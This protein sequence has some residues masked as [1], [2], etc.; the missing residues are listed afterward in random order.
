MST[1]ESK[2]LSRPYNAHDFDDRQNLA[3][4]KDQCLKFTGIVLSMHHIKHNRNTIN[5]RHSD[6]DRRN[7]E[8]TMASIHASNFNFELNHVILPLSRSQF[9]S[10]DIQLFKR[11]NFTAHVYTYHQPKKIY[12]PELHHSILATSTTYSLDHVK[13]FV[14]SN[15]LGPHKL[16][17]YATDFIDRLAHRKDLKLSPHDLRKL[18]NDLLQTTN[19][20]SREAKIEHL[21]HIYAK[22][23]DISRF[24]LGV[25]QHE[26][27][28]KEY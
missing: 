13:H 27:R 2:P 9:E 11:Y 23:T 25:I 15:E 8:I 10:L 16:S 3:P 24:A 18:K 28:K 20:G 17:K 14:P 19:D 4:Y 22:P 1:V 5:T 21:N 6:F 7:Y 12:L 26:N